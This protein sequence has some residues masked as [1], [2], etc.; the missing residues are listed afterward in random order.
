LVAIDPATSQV[1]YRADF[2]VPSPDWSRLYR[3]DTVGSG[4]RL[5]A[6]DPARAS[7]VSQLYVPDG[8]LAIRAVSG[9]GSRVAMASVQSSSG[10]GY[11]AT[12]RTSST[13]VI[14]EPANGTYHRYNVAGN[15]VPEAFSRDRKTVFVIDY[16]PP[17]APVNYQVR[18]FDIS[19]GLVHD[20]AMKDDGVQKPM[21]GTARTQVGSPDGK[22]LYTLYSQ[23]DGARRRAFV[24]VLSL[25]EKWAYCVDLPPEFTDAADGAGALTMSPDGRHLYVMVATTEAVAE[26]DTRTLKVVR[27]TALDHAAK[28]HESG[29]HPRAALA[30]DDEDVFAGLG[31]RVV[32]LDRSDL[33]VR[34]SWS[35]DAGVVAL[36]TNE[37][38]NRLS[39]ATEHS[40]AQLDV[41]TGQQLS[42]VTVFGATALARIEVA[43]VPQA[44]DRGGLSCAC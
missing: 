18:R 13:L 21:G 31:S 3:A 27:T 33:T 23:Q 7:E 42:A 20:V 34:S 15:V 30:A 14:A 37:A 11:H 29:G 2:A 26:L 9:D 35:V 19:D 40:V 43:P 17:E 24:H 36:S 39:V 44:S 25:D 12:G 22:R 41:A 32:T 4:T 16:T 28:D 38:H 1:V 5:T 6:L 8:G 10:V